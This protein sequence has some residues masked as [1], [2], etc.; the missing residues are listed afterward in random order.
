[1]KCKKRKALNKMQKQKKKTLKI[2]FW[3][4]ANLSMEENETCVRDI[5]MQKE[6]RNCRTRL[7]MSVM[8]NT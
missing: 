2:N 7:Y 8:S 6:K 4:A 5:L 3:L 1:M